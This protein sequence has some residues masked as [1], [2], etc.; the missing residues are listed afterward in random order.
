[1][2]EDFVFLCNYKEDNYQ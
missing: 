2:S 1:M